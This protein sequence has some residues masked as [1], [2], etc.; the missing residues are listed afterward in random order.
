MPDTA[1]PEDE[2]ASEL[3]LSI[4]WHAGLTREIV[5]ISGERLTIVFPGHWTH[6]LGPDFRDAMIELEGGRLVTGS[7]ELHHRASDW[8]RHGHH[9]DPAYADVVVHVV[10]V[11]DT[12]E[13]R[14]TDGVVVPIAVLRVSESELRAVQARD[15]SIWTRFGGDVCADRLSRDQ[16]DRVRSLLWELGDARLGQ[17]VTR[18]ESE[19]SVTT[20]ME[21]LVLALF[22]AFGYARNRTQMGHLADRV[23]WGDLL[24]RLHML[25]QNDRIERATAILLGVGGWLPISPAHASLGGLSPADVQTIESIWHVEHPS[26]AHAV[27][28]ADIWETARVRPANHPFARLLTLAALLGAHGDDLLPLLM[29]GIRAGMDPVRILQEHSAP[30]GVNP[31]GEDRSTAIVASILLP[32]AVAY[33]MCTGDHELEDMAMGAWS[34][35]RAA[36]ASR[37]VR[38]ARNQVSGD[39]RIRGLRERGNQGLLYLDRQYCGPRRCYECPIARAVVADD[40]ASRELH[41]VPDRS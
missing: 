12:P 37:A 9:T 31:L 19:L 35:L 11:A 22:D 15:P 36:P 33:A 25:D 23:P 32:F 7:V 13:T 30:R 26:W 18:F 20:P 16:P 17:R 27:L 21:V 8:V 34:S 40:L 14:R 38:R 5:T 6:G 1:L 41:P 29:D 4:A 24:S 10:T 39:V 28:P 3:A 2:G